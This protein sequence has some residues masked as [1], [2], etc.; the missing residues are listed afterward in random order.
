MRVPKQSSMFPCGLLGIRTSCKTGCTAPSVSRAFWEQG[1]R[2]SGGTRCT[3]PQTTVAAA[4][5]FSPTP[6]V[7]S[8]ASMPTPL[9]RSLS[10]AKKLLSNLNPSSNQQHHHHEDTAVW[11]LG[12][13]FVLQQLLHLGKPHPSSPQPRATPGLSTALQKH[14]GIQIEDG[15]T[16]FLYEAPLRWLIGGHLGKVWIFISM[17]NTGHL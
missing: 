6:W 5:P 13:H 8:T 16:C 2:C 15:Q 7:D 4:L 17:S 1:L 11:M 10:R 9:L 12:Y 3:A 14:V